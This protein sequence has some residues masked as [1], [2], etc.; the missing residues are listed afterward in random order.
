MPPKRFKTSG[1]NI[2]RHQRHTIQLDVRCK[3]ELATELRAFCAE[4]KVTFAEV[5]AAGLTA[6][7]T[8]NEK[9]ESDV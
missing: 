8:T 5:L 9:E 4:R 3:P 6:L 7:A 1:P 2:R